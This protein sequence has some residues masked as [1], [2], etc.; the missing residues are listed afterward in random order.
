VS[1]AA[2]VLASLL[3]FGYAVA[4]AFGAWS[5]LRRRSGM[6]MAFMA[7]AAALVVAAVAVGF[8]H[9]A[10]PLFAAAGVLSASWVGYLEARASRARDGA[11]RHVARVG[12]GAAALALVV[13]SRTGGG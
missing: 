9:W 10:A 6:A 1:V 2:G 7:S 3:L 13:L 5:V 4:N 8:G 12:V 11:W